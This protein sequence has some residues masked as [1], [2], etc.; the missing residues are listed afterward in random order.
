MATALE[1]QTAINRF[2]ATTEPK[3][4]AL[5]NG[6]NNETVTINGNEVPTFSKSIFD[7][8]QSSAQAITD[9][10]DAGNALLAAYALGFRIWNTTTESYYILTL[11]GSLGS[12][13]LAWIPE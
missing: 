13:T 4:F 12:E 9:F 10:N 11:V 1:L 5:V 7:F 2:V 6:A 8:E 3:A